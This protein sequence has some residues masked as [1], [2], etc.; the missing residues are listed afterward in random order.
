MHASSAK[1]TRSGASLKMC[2]GR[3]GA[4]APATAA[5]A[6]GRSTRVRVMRLLITGWPSFDWRYCKDNATGI[7]KQAGCRKRAFGVFC[8]LPAASAG[9]VGPVVLFEPQHPALL[10][11]V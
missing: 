6:N 3:S 9:L 11:G 5:C 2:T 8:R 10:E 4:L 1:V 7:A